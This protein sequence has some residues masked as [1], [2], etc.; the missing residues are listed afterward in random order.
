[1]TDQL[2]IKA[3]GGAGGVPG[4]RYSLRWVIGVPVA[5]SVALLAIA[6]W[7]SGGT[8]NGVA[9][10]SLVPP[11]SL[12]QRLLAGV[13]QHGFVLGRASA[14]VTVNEFADLQCPYCDAFA[15]TVFPRL[16]SDYIRPGKAKFVF[17]NYPVLGPDSV[18]GAQ[19][20]T[21]AAR[22][23]LAWQFIEE[24]YASQRPENSGYVTPAFLRTVASSV[25]GLNVTPV[26]AAT[27]SPS[28]KAVVLAERDRER[29][30]VTGTPTFLI[31][32]AGHTP[33][34]VV[35]Y[36]PLTPQL[37]QALARPSS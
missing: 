8:G 9:D 24:F 1:M 5:I 7:T 14:P 20:A 15:L 37:D 19:A 18:T 4:R 34:R 35:G 11:Q 3:A 16:L 10:S 32:A 27:R 12:I 22:Q 30:T 6:V 23:N 36:Y 33:L 31:T 28:I 2:E 25:K 17:H 29:R 21:A 13:P 26:I